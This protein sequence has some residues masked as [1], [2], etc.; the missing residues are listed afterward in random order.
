VKELTAE[1][2]SQRVEY[3]KKIQDLEVRMLAKELLA[4]KMVKD[5]EQQTQMARNEVGKDTGGARCF[6]N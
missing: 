4:Q 3:Q 2:A 5:A 1:M 6:C